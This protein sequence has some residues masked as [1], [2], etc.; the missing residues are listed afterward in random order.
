MRI[1]APG[2]AVQ[3]LRAQGRGVYAPKQP[4]LLNRQH[5]KPPVDITFV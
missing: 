3:E 4:D 2:G 5:V 1:R